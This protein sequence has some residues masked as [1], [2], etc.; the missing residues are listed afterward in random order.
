MSRRGGGKNRDLN[1]AIDGIL[2]VDKPSGKTSHDLVDVIRRHFKLQKVGHG[3]TLDPMAT[4]LLV[5]LLGRGT[6]CSRQIMN[7]KKVYEGR[8]RFG[9]STDSHDKD[10]QVVQERNPAGISREHVEAEMS[11]WIGEIEQIPPMV[12]AIKKNGQP[13]Y[14]LA[15]KGQTVEREP[16]PITIHRF[17][18]LDFRHHEARI[19]LACSKGTYVRTL[20]HDIG[21]ALGVGAHLCELRRTHSGTYNVAE[22]LDI[23]TLEQLDYEGLQAHVLPLPPP[24]GA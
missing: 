11:H 21:E 6:K 9:I 15:R 2:L 13:L 19:V 1:P 20:A 12:S 24:P 5:M 17:E 10:G 22:A 3:G 18:L 14:K 23:E 16:R 8:I 4:G 7:G